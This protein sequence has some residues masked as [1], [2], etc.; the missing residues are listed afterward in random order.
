MSR[1]GSLFSGLANL[2]DRVRVV[3]RDGA[4][5]GV[6]IVAEAQRLASKQGCE[7]FVVVHDVR[8]P[9]VRIVLVKKA[10]KSLEDVD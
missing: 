6:M 5:L 9:L 1:D 8:P 4:D 2:S 10:P 7:L 3:D